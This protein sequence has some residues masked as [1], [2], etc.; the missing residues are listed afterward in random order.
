M[1]SR[2]LASRNL[3]S[4]L[5]DPLS[6][7]L[8]VA[9]P[10]GM[11]LILLAVGRAVGEADASWLTAT[12]LTPGIVLFGFVML[13]FSAAM[14]L[15][16]DRDSSLLARLFTAPLSARG[17]IAGYSVP[18]LPVAAAQAIAL[19]VIGAFYGLTMVGN[20]AWVI[21]VLGLMAVFYIA[22]GMVF[23][24]TLTVNQV[25]GAYAAVLLL[26]IFGG[27]WVDL[28]SLGGAFEAVANVLPFAHALDATR[29][30]M[31]DGAGL[32]DIAVDLAWVGGYTVVTV[33]AAIWLFRR[34]MT[35]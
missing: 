18:Y 33:A 8:A 12:Q 22:L 5:R 35:R 28:A 21:L 30:V 2:Q 9:L 14:G 4:V 1:S 26:T 17:F 7:G 16:R 11:L 20:V 10:V 15:S 25:S 29:A 23:G 31:A 6:L 32:A 13:M 27:A 24:T 34:Q 19:Y 3:K